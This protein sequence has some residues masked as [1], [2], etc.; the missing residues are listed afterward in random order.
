MH[1]HM[2]YSMHVIIIRS[3]YFVW[4]CGE[5]LTEYKENNVLLQWT[6]LLNVRHILIEFHH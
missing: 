3:I 6:A 2:T 4:N 1:L 5:Y